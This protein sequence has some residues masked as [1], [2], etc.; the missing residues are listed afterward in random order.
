MIGRAWSWWWR[1]RDADFERARRALAESTARRQ[2]VERAAPT[3]HARAGKLRQLANEN[4][5]AP[6][7]MR[8]IR[9]RE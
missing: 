2:A 1:R 7:V 9:A 3:V 6:I 4:H 8:A 5:L